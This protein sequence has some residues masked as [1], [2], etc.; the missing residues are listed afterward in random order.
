MPQNPTTEN[1]APRLKRSL[2]VIFFLLGVYAAYRYYNKPHADVEKLKS[3]F[4]LSA[5]ELW[6]QFDQDEKAASEKYVGKI[7]SVSGKV[8]EIKTDQEGLAILL[9][10]SQMGSINCNML[11]A[12]AQPEI[13]ESISIKGICSGYLLDVVMSRCVIEKK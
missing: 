6:Q 7:L 2:I 5:Q 3:D 8:Q 1:L 4:S 13:G 10:A 11:S 12:A 9:E